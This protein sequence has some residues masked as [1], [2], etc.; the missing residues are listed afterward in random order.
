MEIENWRA[1]PTTTSFVNNSTY[2]QC[3]LKAYST[4]AGLSFF[5]SARKEKLDEIQRNLDCA[6]EEYGERI[7]KPPGEEPLSLMGRT[8]RRLIIFA[9]FFSNNVYTMNK[10]I[11]K[12]LNHENKIVNSDRS[13]N[14]R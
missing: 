2:M 12:N 14:K 8:I 4:L 3:L 11:E 13:L 1:L 6:L 10:F 7:R 5:D 9:T